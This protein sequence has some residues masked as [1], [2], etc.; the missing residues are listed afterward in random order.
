MII[1]LPKYRRQLSEIDLSTCLS[2]K[3]L[4]RAPAGGGVGEIFAELFSA[5][6]L[7]CGM[8]ITKLAVFRFVTTRS[9]PETCAA[10]S[11]NECIAL[12]SQAVAWY[13]H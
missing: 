8:L 2:R 13:H 4:I 7:E 1:A 3:S 10:K 11:E 12:S 5:K 9:G 6:K